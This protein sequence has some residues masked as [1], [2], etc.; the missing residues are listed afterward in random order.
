MGMR[1]KKKKH[2]GENGVDVIKLRFSPRRFFL[3]FLF[4]KYI[5]KIT[6]LIFEGKSWAVRSFPT[7]AR[8]RDKSCSLIS[9][10]RKFG[11][12]GS[13]DRLLQSCLSRP[14]PSQA[15]LLLEFSIYIKTD[16]N[17]FVITSRKSI[18]VWLRKTPFYSICLTV[19]P[20][21]PKRP[22]WPSL[23]I[24]LSERSAVRLSHNLIVVIVVL[25]Y[26]N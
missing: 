12:K 2:N 19:C 24:L 13:V 18:K 26:I 1:K 17:C 11:E 4:S 15:G 6:Y 7:A 3:S 20:Q 21:E 22:A 8:F 5:H 10:E 23:E 16:F 14:Q 9:G 25:I